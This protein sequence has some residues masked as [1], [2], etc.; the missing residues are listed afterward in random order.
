[1]RTDVHG[2]LEAV[3]DLVWE[4]L[5]EQDFYGQ[6]PWIEY[7]AA[8]AGV[9]VFFIVVTDD[10]G[11]VRAAAPAYLV[12]HET[13]GRYVPLFPRTDGRR[14]APLLLVGGRRGHRSSLGIDADDPRIAEIV[15]ALVDGVVDLSLET[16]AGDVWCMFLDSPT[17]EALAEDPRI[18]GPH[19]QAGDATAPLPGRDFSDYMDSLTK[20][21]RARVRADRRHFQGA[22]R[23][24]EERRLS[25]VV[26]VMSEVLTD[27]QAS[28]GSPASVDSMRSLLEGQAEHCDASSRVFSSWDGRTPV[29]ATL[30]YSSVHEV[31]S[32]AY[33][34]RAGRADEA[35]DYFELTYYRPAELAYAQGARALHLGIGTLR[36]KT[37]RGALV[38]LR[39]ACAL[40]VREDRA[41]RHRRNEQVMS[42]IV[43]DLGGSAAALDELSHE[44]AARHGAVLDRG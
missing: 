17:A 44:A 14:P 8:A 3:P 16:G 7:Q 20:K 23:S 24:V 6:R 31:S 33:G 26:D 2:G 28:H 35:C 13:S 22:R 21:G 36:T 9:K 15:P 32:R 25:D 34:V 39:W 41:L 18:S 11:A 40:G 27:H 29:A 1:M 30:T 19:L 10:R 4:H 42:R 5:A 37:R 12:D 43:D 38:G